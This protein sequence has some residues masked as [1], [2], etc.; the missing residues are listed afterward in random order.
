MEACGIATRWPHHSQLW[1]CLAS[2]DWV[3]QLCVAPKYHVPLTTRVPK[4]LI[5]VDPQRAAGNA[6]RALRLLQAERSL[7]KAY[8]RPKK[9]KNFPRC[10]L[11]RAPEKTRKNAALEFR[12][13]REIRRDE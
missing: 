2:K 5:L 8:A 12:R 6:L 11:P 3:P 13:L 4:S 7:D 9:E 10:A 1:R